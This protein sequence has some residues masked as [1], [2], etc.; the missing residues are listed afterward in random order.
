MWR[1]THSPFKVSLI[2]SIIKFNL[3]L[4][5]LVKLNLPLL[6]TYYILLGGFP[7]GSVGKETACNARDVGDMGSIP[8]LGRSPGGRRSMATHS[9]ILA[10]R[11]PRTEE[12]GGLQ[13][14]SCKELDINEVTQHIFYLRV[15]VPTN[16]LIAK[17]FTKE[18]TLISGLKLKILLS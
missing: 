17:Q 14:L 1:Q 12:P 6:V 18:E 4:Y 15:Q 16:S 8:V 9:S 3:F 7:D 11:I 13:S 2:I 5:Y 10:W